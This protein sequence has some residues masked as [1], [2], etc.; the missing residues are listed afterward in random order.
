MSDRSDNLERKL[1]ADWIK[2]VR[3]MDE[4]QVRESM[5]KLLNG[6][7]KIEETRD[8]DAQL[9]DF[10]EK[11]ADLS[12]GYRDARKHEALKLDYLLEVL[13]DRGTLS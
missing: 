12:A 4:G 5:V 7:R 13:R 9:K 10:R 11:A 1:D 8:A 6:I 2:S 3:K